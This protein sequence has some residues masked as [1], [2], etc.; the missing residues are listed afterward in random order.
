M[1]LNKEEFLREDAI[2][3]DTDNLVEG[4]LEPEMFGDP[5]M[6]MADILIQEDE[7]AEQDIFKGD[8]S[9]LR[10]VDLVESADNK[11]ES[12]DY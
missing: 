7:E 8:N 12:L 3:I 10:L 9:E 1:I 5:A 6:L 2:G 4:K 11:V